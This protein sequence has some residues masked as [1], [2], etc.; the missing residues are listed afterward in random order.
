MEISKNRENTIIFFTK[1]L[2]VVLGLFTTIPYVNHLIRDVYKICCIWCFVCVLYLFIKQKTRFLKLEYI[3]LFL[4]C[5]SYAITIVVSGKEHFI[6]EV[7]ILGY[8]GMLFFAMTYCDGERKEDEVKKELTIISWIVVGITFVFSLIS[9]LMFLFSV[10][11]EIYH[12]DT[13]YVYG[14]REN[15]LWG[16]YNPNSGSVLNYVSIIVT[17]LLPKK[18]LGAKIFLAINIV[19]QAFCFILTQSRGGWVCLISYIAVYFFFIRKYNFK[20]TRKIFSCFYKTVITA[21]LCLA[22]IVGGNLVKTGL[23]YAPVAIEKAIVS[24]GDE[25]VGKD[26]VLH[27]KKD[28]VTVNLERLDKKEKNL[29]SISTGRSDLWKMGLKAYTENPIVGIGYRSIDDVLQKQMSKGA[30]SNSG[31]GGLHNVYITVL[32]SCGAVGF[33]LFAVYLICV[34]KKVIFGLFNPNISNYGKCIL[35]FIP[36]WLI[37]ELVESRIVLGMNFQ[38]IMFWIMIGYMGYYTKERK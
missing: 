32:V 5:C 11:V 37:G 14:M 6:N 7:A 4:F 22:T 29:E 36:V 9:F 19:V 20:E 10:S 30:Y 35:A 16:L 33:I 34:L 18:K 23:G 21:V 12:G 2:L 25:L 15:R 3:L 31:G 24:D 1:C 17:I 28:K 38:A 13:S 27:S 26:K 8:T